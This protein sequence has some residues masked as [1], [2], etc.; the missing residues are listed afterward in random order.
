MIFLICFF[1]SF[2]LTLFLI[3]LVNTNWYKWNPPRCTKNKPC[4]CKKW[5]NGIGISALCE[6]KPPKEDEEA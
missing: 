4:G 1:A 5:R 2:F 3:D 6:N